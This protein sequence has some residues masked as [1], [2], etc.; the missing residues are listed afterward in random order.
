MRYHYL[1]IIVVIAFVRIFSLITFAFLS[2]SFWF[3]LCFLSLVKLTEGGSTCLT[4]RNMRRSKGGGGRWYKALNQGGNENRRDFEKVS[5]RERERERVREREWQRERERELERERKK[6]ERERRR[7]CVW[8]VKDGDVIWGKTRQDKT[9][10]T[11]HI[12]DIRSE[13]KPL[14]LTNCM[15]ITFRRSSCSWL[16][17]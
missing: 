1:I 10:H 7:E 17:Y 16:K 3:L 12:W 15:M 9:R 11:E 5:V 13:R 2:F 4:M 14:F 6:K 8:D